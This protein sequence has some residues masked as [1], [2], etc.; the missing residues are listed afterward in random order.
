VLD[1][2]EELNSIRNAFFERGIEFA[3]WGGMGMAIY[4]FVRATVDLDFLV[5]SEDVD[6]IEET[7][8]SLGY[9]IEPQR[10]SKTDPID[11]DAMTLDL[12]LVTSENRHV[13]EN[14]QIINWRSMP[15]PVVSRDGLIAL[16]RLRAGAYDLVDIDRLPIEEIDTSDKAIFL[17][18]RRVAQLRN[19]C[20]SLGRAGAE[21][22]RKGQLA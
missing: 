17:R 2:A 20:L 22:R 4:G 13:W 7:A 8:A 10:M 15:L 12:S 5:K 16:K 19:L 9:I 3:V 1:L 18:M 21:A 6:V 11:G 14:R